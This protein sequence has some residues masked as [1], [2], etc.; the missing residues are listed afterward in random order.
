M[1]ETRPSGSGEGAVLSR[2]YLISVLFHWS[3]LTG[4]K[5]AAVSQPGS[6]RRCVI[7]FKTEDGGS[8]KQAKDR[9]PRA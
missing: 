8:F 9:V 7:D 3:G 2:P 4:T 1:R 5:F 6:G